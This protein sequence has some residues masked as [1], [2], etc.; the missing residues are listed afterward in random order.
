MY[1]GVFVNSR[2]P[3]SFASRAVAHGVTCFSYCLSVE[4]NHHG[5]LRFGTDVPPYNLGYRATRILPTLG[6]AHDAAYY[7]SLVGVSLGM[8][9]LGRI[10]PEMFHRREDGQGGCVID[11]GTP[12]TVISHEA[13][14]IIEEAVWAD[15]KRHPRAERVKW[16]DYGLCVQATEAIKGRLPSLSLHFAGGEEE[17]A[18]LVVPPEQ[19]F[20]MMED[21]QAGEIACLAM[22]PGRQTIIGVLQQVDTRFIFDLKDDKLY[23]APESCAR[24]TA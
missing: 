24:D 15:L 2:A 12:L 7:L 1:A 20:L 4:A 3:Y 9:R 23:F 19:M 11:A 22:V 8:R 21:E 13:Y 14:G 16:A 10:R 5:F 6:A 18:T 17:E